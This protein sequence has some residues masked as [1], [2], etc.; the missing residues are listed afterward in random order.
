MKIWYVRNCWCRICIIRHFIYSPSPSAPFW[1]NVNPRLWCCI[2]LS[3][4]FH[5]APNKIKNI[6][7]WVDFSYISQI[8]VAVHNQYYVTG[9]IFGNF[10]SSKAIAR[11][12]AFVVS[13]FKCR[14]YD[15]LVIYWRRVASTLLC[16]FSS[17]AVVS[18]VNSNQ[19][20]HSQIRHLSLTKRWHN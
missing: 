19:G 10:Y 11:I 6:V 2:Y 18:L 9:D 13:L 14:Q 12:S 15:V 17:Y 5:Q 7:R 20:Q 3:I 4:K 16:G 1:I 8:I